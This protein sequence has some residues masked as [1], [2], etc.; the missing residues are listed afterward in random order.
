MGAHQKDHEYLVPLSTKVPA[1]VAAEIER[2]ADLG[3]RSRSREV[4]KALEA[5]I[6]SGGSP[7]SHRPSPERSES[8]GSVRQSS[9]PLLA[10]NE[11]R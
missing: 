10:G 5:H 11:E 4:R 9:S 7:S 3:D 8:S 6:E 2:L 1:R